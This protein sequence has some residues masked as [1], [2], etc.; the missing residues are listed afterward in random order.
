MK[1]I[2]AAALAVVLASAA[3]VSCGD[4]KTKLRFATGGTTGTYYA[5]GGILA[6]E[7]NGK[8]D[9][10]NVI[11][12]STGA[13]KANIQLVADGDAE[14]AVVQNDVM[15]YA[16]EGKDLFETEGKI[17]GFSAV[18]AL[19]A[20]VC[21]LVATDEI[22][23]VADLKGKSVSVGDVGSGVEFNAKQI[24][25]AYGLSFDDINVQNLS[26]GDSA[27]AFKDGKID[28]FFCVAGAPTTAIVDL[29][30]TKKINLVEIDD[31]H[32][33]ALAAEYPFY[34][35]YTIPADT[36]TGVPAAQTVAVKATLIASDKVSEDA[37]YNLLK[38]IFDNKEEITA[39]HDKGKELDL[40]YAVD[41]IAIPFHAGAAKFFA[42]NGITIK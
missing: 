1:K 16:Y 31:E 23:S 40:Q 3:L 42:E 4:T 41:G 24:M 7:V 2:I 13:S 11:T 6:T 9:T 17:E 32:A 36:Y 10:L 28:A 15:Y 12:Q 39:A 21:Q 35:T 30:T 18:G 34:T 22:K 26:F 33:A 19:Y 29:S 20:E 25:A 37:V 5:Y 14:I 38:T 27:D 8:S